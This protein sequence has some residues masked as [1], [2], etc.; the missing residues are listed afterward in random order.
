M[1]RIPAFRTVLATAT[2]ML[3]AMML[4]SLSTAAPR[5]GW[6]PGDH[7]AGAWQRGWRGE[8]GRH[9]PRSAFM[10]ALRQLHL[11]P[12][13]RDNARAILVKAREQA[14]ALRAGSRPDR[15]ALL[16]PGDPKHAAAVQAAQQQ[17]AAIVQQR[18]QVQAQI[19]A[20]LTPEQKTAL[21]GILEQ[22]Q[23]RDERH[24]GP[25]HGG[26]PG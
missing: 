16:N 19:Y 9:G 10:R 1:N 8:R 4:P 24:R 25:R 21:P 11:T 23:H 22:M 26:Y 5:D 12:Q 14:R 18:S 17:A 7:H 2:V 15:A 6:G 13:Q 3:G 20:L